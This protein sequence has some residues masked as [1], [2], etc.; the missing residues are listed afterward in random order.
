MNI[1]IMLISTVVTS[2]IFYLISRN[3]SVALAYSVLVHAV[4]VFFTLLG[5]ILFLLMIIHCFMLRSARKKR[6][7]EEREQKDAAE[8]NARANT[9]GLSS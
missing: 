2:A 1:T 5:N 6:E 8:R 9:G 3:I 7:R 4:L